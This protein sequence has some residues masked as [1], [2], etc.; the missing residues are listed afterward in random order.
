MDTSECWSR[1]V[2]QFSEADCNKARRALGRSNLALQRF[3]D[4]AVADAV[5]PVAAH[6]AAQPPGIKRRH[7][8]ALSQD[9]QGDV[10]EGYTF[11]RFILGTFNVAP[12]YSNSPTDADQKAEQMVEH[13]ESFS[14]D[15]VTDSLTPAAH[16]YLKQFAEASARLG[17]AIRDLGHEQAVAFVYSALI[18]GIQLALSEADLFMAPQI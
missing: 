16:H 5:I 7:Q 8:K 6:V 17:V 2:A 3:R 15:R 4:V 18:A 10:W 12:S 13:A 9:A 14:S 11:A 1:G